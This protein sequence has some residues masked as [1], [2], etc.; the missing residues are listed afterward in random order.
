MAKIN[1]IKP[2]VAW[3]INSKVI[4]KMQNISIDIKLSLSLS[5]WINVLQ[6]IPRGMTDFIASYGNEVMINYG[7]ALASDAPQQ[8]KNH[9]TILEYLLAVSSIYL[10]EKFSK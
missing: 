10:K 6:A 4:D 7:D 5:V 2:G 3:D 8:D 1:R 9:A